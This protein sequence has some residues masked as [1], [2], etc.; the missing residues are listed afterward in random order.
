M[1]LLNVHTK[2]LQIFHN[3]CPDYAILSHTWLEDH[4]EVTYLLIQQPETCTHLTSWRKVDFACQQ[5]IHDGHEWVWIDT[6]CIDKSSS[7]ELSEAINSMFEWYRNSKVCYAYLSDIDA[8]SENA[9]EL[10][11]SR[12]WTRSWTLQ[13]F[14]VSLHV[15]FYDKNWVWLGTKFDH[16]RTI[17]VTTGID[18]FII[19]NPF[20]LFTFSVA[21]RMSWAARREAKRP[22]DIAYALLGIF[23]ISE[24]CCK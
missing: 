12:W 17:A 2:R 3:N 8:L 23:G 15:H 19:R 7:A 5:A 4:L 13:E 20:Q 6:C 24:S 10:V 21:I 11:R 22:E 16:A 14:L 18:E 9:G 1:R